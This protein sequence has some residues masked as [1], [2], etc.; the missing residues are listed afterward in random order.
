MSNAGKKAV[1]LAAL[2][3]FSGPGCDGGGTP[4]VSSSKAETTVKG[5]VMIKGQLATG[6]EITFDPANINRRDASARKAKIE[7]DGSYTVNTLV[8]ENMVSVSGENAGINRQ[9]YVVK[10]GEDLRIDVP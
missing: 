6:G 8:G 7:K 2:M 9:Q 10:M 4:S 3:I 5:T 1:V